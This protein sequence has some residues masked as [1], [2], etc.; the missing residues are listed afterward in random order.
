M[1]NFPSLPS[2]RTSTSTICAP[3]RNVCGGAGWRL[4]RSRQCDKRATTQASSHQTASLRV[5]RPDPLLPYRTCGGGQRAGHVA[6]AGAD[7]EAGPVSP[8]GR[9]AGTCH[10]G[11]CSPASRPARSRCWCRR[12]IGQRAAEVV[13]VPQRHAAGFRRQDIER[14][15]VRVPEARETRA[16][17]L[18][19]AAGG[20]AASCA[21]CRARRWQ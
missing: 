4:L 15:V 3:D 11:R 18:G 6:A 7:V 10:R 8:S 21:R 2:T 14:F 1:T 12:D 17:T 13:A 20:D 5:S 9:C 19:S 16:R